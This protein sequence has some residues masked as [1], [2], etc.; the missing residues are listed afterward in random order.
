[1][2]RAWFCHAYRTS[3]HGAQLPTVGRFLIRTLRERALARQLWAF[4]TLVASTAALMSGYGYWLGSGAGP[5][6]T[7]PTWELL[8]WLL[9]AGGCLIVACAPAARLWLRSLMVLVG[10]VSVAT[11]VW[12]TGILQDWGIRDPAHP[13]S[14]VPESE[15][16]P[17]ELSEEGVCPKAPR[18]A[19]TLTG[20]ERSWFRFAS[21]QQDWEVDS[22]KAAICLDAPEQLEPDLAWMA[23]IVP[24]YAAF[25]RAAETKGSRVLPSIEL[26]QGKAKQ[27]DDGLVAALLVEVLFHSD[28]SRMSVEAWLRAALT[29]VEPDGE[30]SAWIWGAL[31]AGGRL[32]PIEQERLSPRA[33]RFLQVVAAEVPTGLYE[34]SE[35]LGRV[36]RMM[37]YLQVPFAATDPVLRE[38]GRVLEARPDLGQAYASLLR[39]QADLVNSSRQATLRDVSSGAAV[40]A[41]KSVRFL[42]LARSHEV[43]ALDGAAAGG[44]TM[45]TFIEAVRSGRIDLTP[46]ADSGF[47]DWLSFASEPF[48]LPER[49]GE[50]GRLLFAPGYRRRLR[51]AFASLQAKHR[52]SFGLMMASGEIGISVPIA[53]RFRVEPAP[54][55]Y[56]RMASAYGELG[57]RLQKSFSSPLLGA[58]HGLRA[59]GRRAASL[60]EEL[61]WIHDLYL[62][63][64]LVSCQDIGLAPEPSAD[65]QARASMAEKIA[66]DWLAHWSED[67]DM[68][69]D[70]RVAVE[71]ARESQESTRI[72]ATL[73]VRGRLMTAYYEGLLMI[74]SVRPSDGSSTSS[75]YS[76]DSEPAQF[77]LPNDEFAELSARRVPRRS[78]LVR[79]GHRARTRA[80]WAEA[81][82]EAGL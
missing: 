60:L 34:W 19:R 72:W 9:G 38:L 16:S 68:S 10:L 20:T 62:G 50:Y 49:A 69:V 29:V 58:L 8:R 30:A 14:M 6:A 2:Q 17:T 44:G 12:L 31:A 22:S 73:G 52:D 36:Y 66:V 5:D 61:A 48:L 43:D 40:A 13:V 27:I 76:V 26:A 45:A 28:G 78:E 11:A 15:P 47:Y 21:S 80:E 57:H 39:V 42:P 33:R 32:S 51:R 74:R 56:L 64:H 1:M 37:K 7:R 70:T 59:N 41:G 53:P 46:T 81:F 67:P 79:L 3:A 77:V 18:A 75:W 54:T 65:D 35:E 24:S 55:H 63:L 25:A 23:E 4:T 82:E 71:I